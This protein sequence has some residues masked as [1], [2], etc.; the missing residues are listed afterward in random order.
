MKLLIID[1]HPVFREGLVAVLAQLAPDSEV[2]QSPD[3]REG[4]RIA[5]EVGDLDV[6][7]LDIVMPG[8][9]GLAAITEFSRLRPEVPLIVLS[10]SESPASIREAL[11]GGALG[12]IP[13]STEPKAMVAAVK[14]VL[15]GNIYVPPSALR[16]GAGGAREPRPPALETSA[17]LTPRQLEVLG[18][19][20]AGRSN[21]EIANALDLSG[22]TVKAH[23]TTIF[24]A[25]NV[26][27][28]TQAANVARRA[29]LAPDPSPPGE[30]EAP[31][32]V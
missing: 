25:L 5:G 3:A 12:Y 18:L 23:V 30:T 21:K 16:R 20:C 29:G 13:K 10:S 6:I 31:E 27:N 32:I 7:L 15:D 26:I 8:M 14:S 11:R 1:D 22:K 9:D 4:L 17:L 24:K 2:L 19:I 28:R